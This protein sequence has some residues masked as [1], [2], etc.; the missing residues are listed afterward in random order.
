MNWKHLDA[1]M[2]AFATRL[3]SE[4]KLTPEMA[5]KLATTIA[6]DVRFLSSE[7]KAEL[8]AA[9]PVPLQDRLAELQAFQGWM[10]QAHTVR[11]NPFVLENQAREGVRFCWKSCG[12]AGYPLLGDA[13]MDC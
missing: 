13:A 4:V 5:T 8:R 10:D 2:R 11:N 6:A 1:Q 9:S 3:T 7:Q 12:C